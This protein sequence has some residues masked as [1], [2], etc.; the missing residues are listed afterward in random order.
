M[1]ARYS[2]YAILS[3]ASRLSPLATAGWRYS[4]ISLMA[5][6]AQASVIGVAR[7]ETYASTAW[8]RASLPVAAVSAGGLPTISSGSLI[9]TFGVQRQSTIAIF[10]CVLVF[11]M[12][13]NRVISL[14]VPAVVLM[15]R[16]G[17]MGFLLLS[18]PSYSRMFPPFA[19]TMAIPFAQSCALPPPSETIASQPCCREAAR[20][21]F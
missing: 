13:Q 3:R 4:A 10:T 11:V 16:N 21:S 1:P 19:A 8:V 20:P 6:M 2:A 5:W 18:T 12:M 15:A 17:G 9:A 14:A 7:V